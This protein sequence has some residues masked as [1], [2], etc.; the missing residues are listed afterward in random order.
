[1]YFY[2]PNY[3]NHSPNY[4]YYDTKQKYKN[5]QDLNLYYNHINKNEE[6]VNTNV[7]NGNILFPPPGFNYGN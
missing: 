7:M 4:M 6:L 1:M 2:N 5:E 3:P